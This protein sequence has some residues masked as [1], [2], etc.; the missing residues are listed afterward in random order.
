[1]HYPLPERTP[2]DV[3]SWP[4]LRQTVYDRDRAQCHVCGAFVFWRNYECGHIVDRM[5]GGHDRLSNLVTMCRTCNRLKPVHETRDEYATW[6]NTGDWRAS[7]GE[8]LPDGHDL[9]ALYL[10]TADADEALDRLRL[11]YPGKWQ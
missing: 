1:M 2:T 11:K 6:I 10:N 9:L 3:H 4:T 5:C 7:V 8:R